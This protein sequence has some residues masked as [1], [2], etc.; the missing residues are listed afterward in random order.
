MEN[1]V[2]NLLKLSFPFP[3][4]F[5]LL[6]LSFFLI[7]FPFLP[8][9]QAVLKRIPD[10]FARTLEPLDREDL[11]PSLCKLAVAVLPDEE[12]ATAPIVDAAVDVTRQ[13]GVSVQLFPLLPK[14][15]S[16]L[17]VPLL[18]A[19]SSA[20]GEQVIRLRSVLAL[21]S[22]G[23]A[24]GALQRS[25]LPS[26]VLT[27]SLEGHDGH[28]RLHALGLLLESSSTSARLESGDFDLIKAFYD[29]D[30]GTA[31][32]DFRQRMFSHT[33]KLLDRL[34]LSSYAAA[35]DAK[36]AREGDA[37]RASAEAYVNRAQTFLLR[38]VD[39]VV[40]DLR[41]AAPYRV[42]IAALRM[43]EEEQDA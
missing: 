1:L 29:R 21:A 41:P 18:D 33:L 31:D 27:S 39:A 16:S 19:L 26:D 10:L 6:F 40:H 22:V 37:A 32:P 24:A 5:S 17:M 4:P 36:R 14:S 35:R 34:R 23:L 42:S 20:H 3:F 13:V 11:A 43:L 38:R 7:F 28:L 30:L 15:R 8:F 12:A 25:D 2:F 9:R